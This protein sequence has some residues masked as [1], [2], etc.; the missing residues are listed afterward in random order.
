MVPYQ[1]N[2]MSCFRL[3]K[4]NASEEETRKAITDR[5]QDELLRLRDATHALIKRAVGARAD[6]LLDHRTDLLVGPA[7]SKHAVDAAGD[8]LPNGNGKDASPEKEKDL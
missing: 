4:S 5:I 8:R 7:A 3:R 6:G 1:N 2:I